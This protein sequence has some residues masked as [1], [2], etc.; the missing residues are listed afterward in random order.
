MCIAVGDPTDRLDLAAASMAWA[1]SS[2][3][4]A[5][6]QVTAEPLPIGPSVP[7]VGLMIVD[8]THP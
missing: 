2:T 4:C 5:R 8:L 1:D 7:A 3:I 6:R